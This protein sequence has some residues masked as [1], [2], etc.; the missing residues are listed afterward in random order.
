MEHDNAARV[1]QAVSVAQAVAG[2][3][4]IP[5]HRPRVLHQANNVVVHLAPSPV[6]A[7]VSTSPEAR[8]WG[9]LAAELDIANHLI[10]A[11]APVVGVCSELPPGPHTAG[12]CA[13]TFWQY[14][15]HDSTAVASE[16]LIAE[17]LAEVHRALDRYHGQVRS[18]LDRMVRRTADVL[19][20]PASQAVLPAPDGAFLHREYLS[21]MAALGERSFQRRTLHGDPHRGNFLIDGTS[22]VMIDFE[23]ACSGPLEWDLSALPGDGGAV[24]AADEELLRLLQRLRSVCVVVWCGMRSAR[25]R[26]LASAARLHLELLRKAA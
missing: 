16:R 19:A 6:V 5:V 22:C 26:E 11:G 9:R 3:Y 14:H 23:S 4:G 21:I 24:F 8:G 7:K 25:S 17:T 1:C 12:G 13:I 2:R 18:F 10:Q 20:D 15:H